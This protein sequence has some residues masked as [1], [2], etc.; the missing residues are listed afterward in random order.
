MTL[1]TR[2]IR[3]LVA[4]IALLLAGG[5]FAAEAGNI[6]AEQVWVNTSTT[7]TGLS[8]FTTGNWM[9]STVPTS[10]SLTSVIN[11]GT[12]QV[13]TK[14]GV[15]QTLTIDNGSIVEV[16]GGHSLTV[17]GGITIN[18]GTLQLG[19]SGSTGTLV[20]SVNL[21]QGSSALVLENSGAYGGTISG[22]GNIYKDGPGN[23]ALTGANI[24]SYFGFV[25]VQQGA[26]TLTGSVGGNV[27]V[28]EIPPPLSG[29]TKGGPP[30]ILS[31]NGTVGGNLTN[32]GV[33]NPG[34]GTMHVGFNYT[35][36]A[37]GVLQIGIGGYGPNQFG[38][39]FV[40]GA[41]TLNGTVKFVDLGN[42]T[43]S[44]GS[45]FVFLTAKNQV[46]ESTG[47][48]TGVFTT[49]VDPSPLLAGKLVYL[50]NSVEL[51]ISQ[52]PI[53]PVVGG[54]AAPGPS[55]VRGLTPNQTAVA[56]DLDGAL[57]DPRLDK[58]FAALDH[59]PLSEIPGALDLIA[60]AEL[61]AIYE[62]GIG[63]AN[64]QAFNLTHHLEDLQAGATGFNASHFN[65]D[66]SKD[67][68]STA[69][70]DGKSGKDVYTPSPD[71]PWSVFLSGSGEFLDIAGD[72]NARGYDI[73]TGGF[74]LGVDYRVTPNFALGLLTGYAGTGANLAG[75]GHIFVDSGKFG[76]YGTW[77]N[78]H[79]YVNGLVSGGYNSYDIRRGSLGGMAYG[80]TEGGELNA[81]ITAG[82]NWT[83]GPV[84]F[85]PFAE[86]QYTYVSYDGYQEH[87]SLTPLDI[88]GNNS[89]SLRTRLGGKVSTTMKV[90]GFRV[91]P[92]L[93]VSWQHEFGDTT[94][95]T[96]SQ[97]ASGAGDVF[98][99][100]GPYV[101]RDSI[102]VNAV[103]AVALSERWST[104]LGYDG[105][106]ARRSYQSNTV[107]GGVL[108][109][110]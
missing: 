60:P 101:G 29:L 84:K 72:Y 69:G 27:I 25:Y 61:S 71:N 97:L 94:R 68:K 23:F 59:L 57:T 88:L 4:S 110:F 66:T 103:I 31:G 38:Q 50:A 62:I 98:R 37:A 13:D 102:I 95:P 40:Q 70:P 6:Q 92:E 100:E 5:P 30:P 1:P 19:S 41:A 67:G 78:E 58:V 33:V 107:S 17:S 42:F 7:G 9:N 65:L 55:G 26:L 108:W 43:P 15:S 24:G 106:L 82:Y 79:C 80:S 49:V 63:T 48:I 74:T 10:A 109:K 86:F 20:G 8:W 85:G 45:T 105:Q 2:R 51:V 18:T 75:S 46:Q 53:L 35:Q 104:Y 22:S 12:A 90:G 83:Q 34:P 76:L 32:G 16:I 11:G 77:F 56:I 44:G 39:L 3:P 81:L 14:N 91:S 73:T 96:D 54:P 87:G 99:V 52:R 36:E 93:R 89:D 64:V 47:G 28:G 21:T